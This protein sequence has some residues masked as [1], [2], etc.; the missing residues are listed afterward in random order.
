[1]KI[2]VRQS[3]TE[4]KCISMLANFFLSKVDDWGQCNASMSNCSSPWRRRELKEVLDRTDARLQAVKNVAES[5]WGDLEAFDKEDFDEILLKFEFAGFTEL[6]NS[7]GPQ[8]FIRV[9]LE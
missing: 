2:M 4:P 5:L 3:L 1:M 7:Q 8:R 6:Q 9:P